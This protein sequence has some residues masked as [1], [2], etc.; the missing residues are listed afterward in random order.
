MNNVIQFPTQSI[1][2]ENEVFTQ[3]AE[4]LKSFSMSDI[5]LGL[6]QNAATED[7]I[8]II[9]PAWLKVVDKFKEQGKI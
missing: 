1:E 9:L 6:F 5:I 2:T 7:D 3:T 4:L 8:A